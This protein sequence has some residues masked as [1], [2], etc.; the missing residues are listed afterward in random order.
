MKSPAG[1]YNERKKHIT[2][3]IVG[4]KHVEVQVMKIYNIVG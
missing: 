3:V 4:Y 2:Q 1:G